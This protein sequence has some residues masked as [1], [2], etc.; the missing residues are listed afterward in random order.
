MIDLI[1]YPDKR[2]RSLTA[3]EQAGASDKVCCL[4]C[5]CYLQHCINNPCVRFSN[6]EKKRSTNKDCIHQLILA[7]ICI[8][9]Y[10]GISVTGLDEELGTHSI[11]SR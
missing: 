10:N 5:C 7:C 11:N 3:S 4:R 1:R 9:S 8:C 2:R 6:N